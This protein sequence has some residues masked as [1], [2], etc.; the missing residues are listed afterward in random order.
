M[1]KQ[2][3]YLVVGA[4][5]FGGDFCVSARQAGKRVLVIDKRSH[6]GGN[7]HCR[8]ME[9]IQVHLYGPHIFHTKSQK[10]WDF[11][12]QFVSFNR[13]TLNTWLTIRE[14]Y[15]I[16]HSICILSIRCGV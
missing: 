13:F 10:V 1:K 8:E 9:G 16:C 15:T 14:N 11:V 12:N 2:Y 4:G 7:V 6:T 3:D 5:L